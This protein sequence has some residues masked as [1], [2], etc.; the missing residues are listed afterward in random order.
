M[1]R[2]IDSSSSVIFTHEDFSI[3]LRKKLIDLPL[4]QKSCLLEVDHA[5]ERWAGLKE[6]EEEEEEFL[7]QPKSTIAQ[8]NG[9]RRRFRPYP[10]SRCPN[11]DICLRPAAV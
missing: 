1:S 4:G 5:K 6:E 10:N 8:P 7:L 3:L 2:L 11:S 9:N